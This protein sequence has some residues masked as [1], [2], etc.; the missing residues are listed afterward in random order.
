M[1]ISVF[2]M[3]R[4]KAMSHLCLECASCDCNKPISHLT[5]EWATHRLTCLTLTPSDEELLSF[6]SPAVEEEEKEE[7]QRQLR[8]EEKFELVEERYRLSTRFEHGFGYS[9]SSSLS[10]LNKSSVFYF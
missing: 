2:G 8:E 4:C 9:L 5:F 1:I 6:F 3:I 7:E 10:R